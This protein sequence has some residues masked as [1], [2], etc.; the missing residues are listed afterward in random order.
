MLSV[1]PLAASIVVPATRLDAR[2]RFST[3]RIRVSVERRDLG[4]VEVGDLDEP[5]APVARVG[6]AREVGLG[7]DHRGADDQPD[8]DRELGDDQDGCAAGRCRAARPTTC[9]P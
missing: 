7:V 6:G 1:V 8:R 9:W 5:V 2:R 3:S 4:A